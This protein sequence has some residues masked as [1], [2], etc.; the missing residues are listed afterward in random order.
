MA[1]ISPSTISTTSQ[2]EDKAIP[3][4]ESN[5]ARRQRKYMQE[6]AVAKENRLKRL[7][8]RWCCERWE[9]IIM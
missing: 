4:R 1:I 3:L 8:V 9:K 6:Q 7:Q 5:E 2:T